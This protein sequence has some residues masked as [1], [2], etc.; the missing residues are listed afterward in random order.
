MRGR[1]A[2]PHLRSS[3]GLQPPLR[4]SGSGL[5]RAVASRQPGGLRA[6]LLVGHPRRLARQ[7]SSRQRHGALKVLFFD[8]SGLCVFDKRPDKGTFR[9]PK[10]LNDKDTTV[11]ID[12]RVLDDLLDGIDVEEA[13]LQPQRRVRAH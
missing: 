2:L 9:L 11:I 5:R 12:E 1:I 13:T 6:F 4:S 3:G 7:G 10:A 8:G